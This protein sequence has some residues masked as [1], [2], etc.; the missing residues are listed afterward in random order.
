M[1][2][3]MSESFE[4]ILTGGHPNSLGRTL[5]VVD[6]ILQDKTKLTELLDTYTSSDEVVRLRVSNALKR[7]CK[8]HPDWVYPY[9]NTLLNNISQIKQ[10]ST[11]WTLATV[12]RLLSQYLT[13]DQKIQA[14]QHFK[15]NLDTHTD[16]IVINTTMETLFEWSK[17]DPSLAKWLIPRLVTFQQDSH[18]SISNRASKYL[19]ILS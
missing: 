1:F 17:T 15:H 18:K 7:I 2:T 9:T 6:A 16:W 8:E 5:E 12:F 11:Q 13:S 14:I 10:A 19:K 3:L 4:Q